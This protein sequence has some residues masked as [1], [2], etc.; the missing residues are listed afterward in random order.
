MTAAGA[1]AL[2]CAAALP[3]GIVASTA[4][5]YR[6]AAAGRRARRDACPFENDDDDARPLAR[7]IADVLRESGARL[8][9]CAGLLRP[10]PR[11]WRARAIQPGAGPIVVL[12]AARSMQVG[13]M[14]P[15]GHRLARDLDAS[16][17]VEPRG[18]GDTATRALRVADHVSMLA[19]MAPKRPMLLVGHDAGGLVVRRAATT[20]RL[21]NLRVVTLATPHRGAGDG[22]DLVDVVN[23]YSLHDARIDPPERAY[24]AGAFNVALRDHGHVGLLRAA[25]PYTILCESLADLAPHAAAS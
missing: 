21:P 1:I 24:L 19:A 16:I 2:L 11:R 25:Q 20:L 17:H 4:H 15:L 10:V 3:A 23:I 14:A 22:D 12:V 8:R 5:A 6:R 18:G 7:E 9:A 13:S